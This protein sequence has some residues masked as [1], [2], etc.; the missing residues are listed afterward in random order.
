MLCMN[1]LESNPFHV[2]K[3]RTFAPIKNKGLTVKIFYH[4]I[5][6]KRYFIKKFFFVNF[7][8]IFVSQTVQFQ[9]NKSSLCNFYSYQMIDFFKSTKLPVLQEPELSPKINEM[10]KSVSM[11]STSGVSKVD[12]PI[13]A[14]QKNIRKH[15]L[16]GNLSRRRPALEN[17]I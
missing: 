3:Q 1:G 17:K 6:L 8:I 11:F 7:Y 4:N 14:Q 16:L 15:L 13:P 2:S 12:V 5:G 9:L 10:V